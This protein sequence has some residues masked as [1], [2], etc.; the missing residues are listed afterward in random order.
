[1]LGEFRRRLE[2]Y[3]G[4]LIIGVAGD[5]GSGKSTFTKSISNLLGKDMV[6]FF[7]LDDYHLE[8][9]ETRK[10]TGHLPLD[11][12]INNLEL[13]GEHLKILRKGK[14]IIKPVYNHTTGKFDPPQVFE[15]KK[16]VIVEGLHALYDELR[17]FLDLKIYVDPSRE[18]KWK[19][20]IKRDVNERGYDK[21]H[22]IEEIRRR[23][24]LYKR[25]I[26]FQKVYADVVIKIDESKFSIPE[27]Y[28]VEL[29]MK[30]L[31]FPLSGIDIHLDLSSLINTSKKPMELGYKDDFYYMK[32]VS[33]LYFDG[34]IPREAIGEL[35]RKIIEYTGFMEHH[36][37]EK[38]EYVNSIQLAQLLVA[39]YFVEMMNNIFREIEEL[40]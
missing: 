31:D 30:T 40:S 33:R 6:S 29:I 21:K 9:R 16:I 1:M 23:E 10:K 22:V 28:R 4:S 5:S 17:N 25:Y 37:I 24:P 13:A 2:N 12:K 15:P 26:D 8:D 39:W 7:S 19:W 20:K 35:E 38:S 11:P 14:A 34:L 18:I 3:K 32:R 27:S 36:I